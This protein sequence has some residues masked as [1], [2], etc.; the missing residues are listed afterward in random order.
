MSDTDFTPVNKATRP[1][2]RPTDPVTAKTE[3]DPVERAARRAAEL[4]NHSEMVESVDEYFIEPGIIPDK[5]SYEWKRKTVYGAEDPAH[6]VSL[7]RRGWEVVPASRH[8]E[9][10]P[11][12]YTGVEITRKGMILMERPLEITDEVRA[13]ELRKARLQVRAKE[14]QL[15]A[16]PSG[17]FERSNKGNDLVKVKKGYEAISIPDE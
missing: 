5:W 12:G 16:S 9:M 10:M 14:E 13:A 1:L 2:M 6:Q 4:R 7:A 8:P 15:T 17:Q 3:E 11:M